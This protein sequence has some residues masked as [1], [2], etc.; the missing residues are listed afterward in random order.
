MEDSME[1]RTQRFQEYQKTEK[2]STETKF[3]LVFILI[4]V[5][6]WWFWKP[7]LWF[8]LIPTLKY[9]FLGDWKKEN[10]R[11]NSAENKTR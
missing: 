1:K 4:C 11:I 3:W 7:A 9:M 2:M 10:D 6:L 5:I 8:I